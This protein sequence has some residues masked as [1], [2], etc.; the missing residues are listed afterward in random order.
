[1]W[2]NVYFSSCVWGGRKRVDRTVISE[3]NRYGRSD[4]LQKYF[5]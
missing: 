4:Y 2:L 1:M 5:K 3:G